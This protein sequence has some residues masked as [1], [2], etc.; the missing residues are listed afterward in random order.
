MALLDNIPY[1][2]KQEAQLK[3]NILKLEQQK[4]TLESNI[5][6]LQQ[7]NNEEQ[8]IQLQLKTDNKQLQ[9]SVNELTEKKNKLDEMLKNRNKMFVETELKYI[10][11][12]DGWSFEKYCSDLLVKLGYTSVTTKGSNDYGGDILATYNYRTYVIQCKRYNQPVSAKP[13]GEVLRSM[14][15]YKCQNGVILTNSTFTSNAI[16][17]AQDCDVELWDRNTLIAYLSF[18]YDINLSELDTIKNNNSNIYTND[19]INSIEANTAIERFDVDVTDPLLFE[20]IEHTIKVGY[21]ATS[22]IQRTFKV[23]YARAG[24]IIDQ[25]EERGIISGYEGTKPRKVLITKERWEEL[26]KS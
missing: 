2:K 9:T 21:T 1:F 8:Q 19:V 24:R 10:D 18:V 6:T 20:A 23:G 5:A 17:E 4:Q 14:K 3:Q 12:L 11:H 25:M 7:T 22:D 15:H 26:K 16:E 13:I